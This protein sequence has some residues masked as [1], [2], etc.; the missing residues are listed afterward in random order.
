MKNIYDTIDIRTYISTSRMLLPSTL[1]TPRVRQ[2]FCTLP[3]HRRC[4]LPSLAGLPCW[5]ILAWFHPSQGTGML[6]I[7]TLPPLS[8]N[9]LTCFSPGRGANLASRTTKSLPPVSH[10]CPELLITSACSKGEGELSSMEKQST[11]PPS[12]QKNFSVGPFQT[13]TDGL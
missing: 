9:S 12:A 13:E 10:A 2:G 5:D 6:Q 3:T 11:E 8:S 7:Q 4:L 1:G